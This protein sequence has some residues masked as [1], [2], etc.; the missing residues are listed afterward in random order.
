MERRLRPPQG[1]HE[2]ASTRY[3]VNLC[4]PLGRV[5][6]QEDGF[7][8]GTRDQ[9]ARFQRFFV[10]DGSVKFSFLGLASLCDN[11]R[12]WRTEI[13]HSRRTFAQSARRGPI[14][15][16]VTDRANPHRMRAGAIGFLPTRKN[17]LRVRSPPR[18]LLK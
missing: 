1:A 12:C 13:L 6:S 5:W 17:P 10:L 4:C 16:P 7:R 15:S 8:P 3:R 2:I 11:D 18:A 9:T 14:R